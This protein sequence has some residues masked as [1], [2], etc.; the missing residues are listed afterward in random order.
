M[1]EL[2]SSLREARLRRQVDLV[3]AEQATK[4]R[5]KYLRALEEERFEL[6]PAETY[7][8]GFLRSYAEYLGLDGQLYVDE[9]NS[10]YATGEEEAPL[11]ARRRSAPPPRRPVESRG[12]ILVLAAIV[13]VTAL[14]IAA[15]R[16]GAPEDQGDL[17][18][19]GT[20]AISRPKPTATPEAPPRRRRATARPARNAK[21]LLRAAL[22]ETWIEVRNGSAGGEQLFAGTLEQG[23]TMGFEKRRLWLNIGRPGTLVVRVNGKRR[24]LPRTDEPVV[25]LVT[26][27]GVRPASAAT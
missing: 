19:S 25:V 10:R 6:L 15:W 1:F 9:Y 13:L 21:L 5:G 3:Q 12:V 11:R 20:T 17:L 4:I 26:P 14:V 2:G 22:G 18:Q 16:F 23:R 7:V 8:K 27:S 24:A